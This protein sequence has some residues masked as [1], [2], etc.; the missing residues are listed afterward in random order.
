MRLFLELTP[1][2]D[3]TT[4]EYAKGG[5]KKEIA[6]KKFRAVSTINNQLQTAFLI[7]GVRNR[8]ELS[9][10]YAER[11]TGMKI[12]GFILSA[13]IICCM[14]TRQRPVQRTCSYRVERTINSKAS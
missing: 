13:A 6:Q 1:E 4:Q 11:L 8:S 9:L 14:A 12:T 7:L 5:E 3:N 2:C 10:K